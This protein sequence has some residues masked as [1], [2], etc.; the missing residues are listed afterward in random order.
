MVWRCEHGDRNPVLVMAAP[1]LISG[2]SHIALVYKEGTP[3]VYANGKLIQEGKKGG[4]IIHPGLGEAYLSEGASYY[5]GDMN[6]PLLFSE[7]LSAERIRQLAEEESR[8]TLSTPFI[9]EIT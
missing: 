9:T 8:L 5:N 2:C 3:L 4:K 7:V 1:V 6:K